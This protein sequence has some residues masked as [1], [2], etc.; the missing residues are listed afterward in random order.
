MKLTNM[1]LP[2]LVM[3]ALLAVPA[4]AYYGASLDVSA[5]SAGV[6]PCDIVSSS[7]ISATVTNLGTDTDTFV[8]SMTIPHGWSGFILPRITL[9]SGESG[10][11]T[12][13]WVTAP[14]GTPS[15]SYAITI[16]AESGMSGKK[17]E[18]QAEINIITCY[19]VELSSSQGVLR[20]C[21]GGEAAADVSI[22]NHG[23]LGQEFSLAS[24]QVWASLSE[25]RIWVDAGHAKTV[26]LTAMPPLGTKSPL[27]ITVSAST[28]TSY[29][30]DSI[31]LPLAIERCF[32]FNASV[33]PARNSI[34]FGG[35]AELFVTID[36]LGTKA[37]TF[38]I[39]TQGWAIADQ[40]T[41]S[42]G[43][44]ERKAVR[45]LARPASRGE[46]RLAVSVASVSH[47]GMIINAEA[48]VD[49]K[50]CRSVAVSLSP[51]QADICRGE[52]A[53]FVARVE[54]TGTVTTAFSISS[55][56]GIL[57]RSKLALGP[58]EAQNVVLETGYATR[59]GA[60]AVSVTVYDGNV[61]DEDAATLNVHDCYD[62]S[63]KVSPAEALACRGDTMT[64]AVEAGNPGDNSDSYT[65]S[66]P[67]GRSEKFV[68]S[69]GETRAFEAK[70]PVSHYWNTSNSIP[71]SLRSTKGA[72][73]EKHAILK[74]APRA[75]CYAVD[76]SIMNGGEAKDKQATVSVG[77]GTTITLGI[78][79]K[80]IR[81]D[82][83]AIV[84]NG[85]DWVHVSRDSVYLTPLQEDKVYVYLSPPYGIEEKGHVVDILASSDLSLSG[86]QII[87]HVS[88][89]ATGEANQTGNQT[90]GSSMTGMF[91]FPA[92][93]SLK[94][95][96]I[97]VLAIATVAILVLRFLVFK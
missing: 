68:L 2:M 88:M 95:L 69:S 18:R 46:S 42:I 11:I 14:C 75:K 96:S 81:P 43:S 78:V 4:S 61:T 23:K 70:V 74:V 60:H 28:R 19:D 5:S 7:E 71:F 90:S 36:N 39:M 54:N 58:G 30:R 83:F 73:I 40:D 15:G 26:R 16:S 41:V 80:G 49:A 32:A 8:M 38:R 25:S 17:V 6:C 24:S 97:L 82:L 65:L 21:E 55:S 3:T 45:I 87:A 29:A 13:L 67:D 56:L 53:T 63:L 92:P 47:P 93:L 51:A 27:D 57:E 72:Y 34:C 50:D 64:Y 85:P 35:Q 22:I 52:N 33:T 94:I 66:L 31:T 48:V 37:D 79:N 76:L 20:A 9:A 89:N 10:V 1:I 62:A 44:I 59:A 91:L 12:P 77:R 86:V 84:V